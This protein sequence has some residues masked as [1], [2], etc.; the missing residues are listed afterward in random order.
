DP[1]NWLRALDALAQKDVVRLIPGHGGQGTRETLLGQRAYLANMINGVR[2]GLAARKSLD[3]VVRDVD[4]TRH[5]PWG[6]DAVR[7]ENSIRAIYAKF[8]KQK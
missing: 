2:D 7:N 5:D 8:S 3:E 1:D 6:K 4:V